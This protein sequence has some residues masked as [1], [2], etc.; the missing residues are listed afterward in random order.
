MP[1]QINMAKARE[2]HRNRLR[3]ARTPLLLDLDVE[4]LR[5]H[6]AGDDTAA[7][8]A[9]KQVLRDLPQDPAIDTATTPDELIDAWPAEALGPHTY[10]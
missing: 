3:A 1:I 6:E 8:V 9:A 10:P 5:A 4:Y 2:I 7:I